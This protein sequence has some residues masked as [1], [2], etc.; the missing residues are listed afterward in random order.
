MS[1]AGGTIFLEGSGSSL[2]V[3]MSLPELSLERPVLLL[4]AIVPIAIGAWLLTRSGRRIA[5]PIDH[6]TRPSRN[7][8][9][10][11]ISSVELLLP[12][13][14]LIAVVIACIP[15]AAGNPVNQRRLTN[16]EFC[17]DCSGSMTAKFGEGN[18]YDASMKAINEFLN[19]REGDAFGLTFFATDVVRWCPL[20]RDTSAF[21]CALPF[22]KPDSQ[23]AIGGGTM[24]GRALV[25]CRKVLE[26]QT[27]GDRMIILVSD[28][29]SADLYNGADQEI[30]KE[31]LAA[32]ISVYGIHIGSSEIPAEI[33]SLTASTG[34]E[35]FVS[36]DPG[37]LETV[38]RK[39]DTMK[40]AE[41]E[42]VGIEYV[43]YLQPFCL[44]GMAILG[45]WM[46]SAFGLRY[47]PW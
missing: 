18:R 9:Q 7:I 16:I 46:L 33:L 21:R 30:A 11:L 45:V 42:T 38:F 6:G 14:L 23:R 29:Q 8:V 4:A 5:I 39:I 15:L 28:G 34:G 24:I 40:P 35:A 47:T 36:G 12:I 13:L 10:I 3:A 37:A 22:M 44:A 32:D 19:Y 2:T 25:N 17:V 20:T 31:L 27:S 26:Q 41:I 1:P 43:D